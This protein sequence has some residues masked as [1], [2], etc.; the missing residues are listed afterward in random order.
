MNLLVDTEGVPRFTFETPSKLVA[1]IVTEP[2]TETIMWS[3]HPETFEASQIPQGLFVAGPV[4]EVA[5]KVADLINSRVSNDD[6]LRKMRSVANV[7]YGVVPEGF[8]E[9]V[10][11]KGLRGG[12]EYRVSA[13]GAD[14]DHASKLFRLRDSV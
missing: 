11:A 10:H 3:V 5:V 13:T 12:S 6:A 8:V 4:P 9:R 1:L 2:Q 14:F 7:T